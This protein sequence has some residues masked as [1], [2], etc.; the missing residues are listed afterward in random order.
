MHI[1]YQQCYPS[2]PNRR[3]QSPYLTKVSVDGGSTPAETI[4]PF[5]HR[6]DREYVSVTNNAVSK[7]KTHPSYSQGKSYQRCEMMRLTRRL[8]A[9]I[10]AAVLL[11]AG[12]Q[13][14]YSTASAYNSLPELKSTA[15][16]SDYLSHAK[17][18]CANGVA[19]PQPQSKSDL[20][21]DCAALL[22]SMK[23]LNEAGRNLKGWDPDT[24]IKKWEGVV[25]STNEDRVVGL[26]LSEKQISGSIPT[27][28]GSLTALTKLDLSRNKLSGSIPT[29]L[30]SL[31]ALTILKLS[32][33]KLSGTIPTELGSL[34]A[35]TKLD[36]SHNKLSGSI[37]TELGS[38][39]YLTILRLANNSLSGSIPTELGSLTAL[40]TLKLS[41]NKL[42]GTIPTELGSLTALTKL[43][44]SHNSLSGSFPAELGNLTELTTLKLENTE[45]SGSL[46]VELMNLKKLT[47]LKLGG[48]KFDIDAISNKLTN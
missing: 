20:V 34:T 45:L 8:T 11:A 9:V 22:L 33:N 48:N 32:R 25:L 2:R 7:I 27:E 37:P 21:D 47:T 26:K 24:N 38:L 1:S 18:L 15:K 17:T 16:V 19:V 31:T 4:A 40:T 36:L 46:P 23:A 6:K 29:E 10:A 14:E 41:R 39:T 5:F 3:G 12:L 30:G 28:L 44:L 13:S 42:S 43:N 35:L